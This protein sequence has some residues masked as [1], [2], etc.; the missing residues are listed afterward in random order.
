M[1][2]VPGSEAVYACLQP[3]PHPVFLRVYFVLYFR[4]QIW[5]SLGSFSFTSLLTYLILLSPPLTIR[6]NAVVHKVMKLKIHCMKTLSFTTA[7]QSSYILLAYLTNYGKAY[8]KLGATQLSSPN[9]D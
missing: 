7:C 6:E 3:L 8:Y 1:T 9:T 5:N 4:T 2:S